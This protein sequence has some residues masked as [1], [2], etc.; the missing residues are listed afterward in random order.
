MVC[1]V[2]CANAKSRALVVGELCAWGS[3]KGVWLGWIE[4][5]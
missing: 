1:L 4:L 2:T 5:W 3:K